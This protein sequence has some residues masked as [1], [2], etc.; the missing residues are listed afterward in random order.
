[1]KCFTKKKTQND[2]NRNIITKSPRRNVLNFFIYQCNWRF[3]YFTG[4]SGK[5]EFLMENEL[6]NSVFINKASITTTIRR[7]KEKI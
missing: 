7:K 5:K 6:S 3:S 1:M 2:H 4:K